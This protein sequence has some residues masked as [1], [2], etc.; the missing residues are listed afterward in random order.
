[1]TDASPRLGAGR[2]DVPV[3]RKPVPPESAWQEAGLF[4]AIAEATEDLVTVVDREARFL[5]VN[6]AGLRFLGPTPE[7]LVG[8]SALDFVHPD[9]Q[10]A[11][12]EAV[13]RW[14]EGD[15]QQ[16]RSIENRQMHRDGSVRHV[17][18]TVTR[19][20]GADGGLVLVSYAKDITPIRRAERLLEERELRLRALLSGM[21][22]AVVAIDPSG[23]VRF[24]SDSVREIFGWEPS[25]LV[26]RNVSVLLPEPHRSLHDDYLARY[27]ETGETWILNTT[28]E[29]EARHR[30]G[31]KFWIELSVSRIDVPG[32]EP[33]FCGAFRDITERKNAHRIVR[34][35]EQRF[36]AIFDQEFQMVGL[37]EPSGRVLEINRAAIQLVGAT[38]E[39]VIGRV[40]WETPWWS[41]SPEL[42]ELCRKWVRRA[43]RGEFVRDEI[44]VRAANGESHVM[45]FSLK[46]VRGEE[47]RVELLIPEA[48]D[49]TELKRA[50]D[51]ETSMLRALA[52]LGE[53]ASL[54]AHEIKNPITSI[55]LALRAVASKLG[56]DE[57]SAIDD[58]LDRLRRLEATLRRTLSFAKPL[59][60]DAHDV[61]VLPLLLGP[62]DQLRPEAESRDVEL[63]LEVDRG[64]GVVRV[65][66]GL[67]GDLIGNLVRNAIDAVADGGHVS[68][69]AQAVDS[70]GV[71]IRVE[72]DGPGIPE[73]VRESL[74]QPFVTTKDRGTGLGLPLARKVAEEHGG[75]LTAF[76]SDRLGGACFQ[77]E[78]PTG[79]A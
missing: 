4:R 78:L 26:G 39:D 68:I 76:R 3:P 23:I 32:L 40:F 6:S 48:R 9:D 37:L 15:P 59:D 46:P 64:C 57:A 69:T 1:M 60:I 5:F 71:R 62:V 19:H 38:R 73:S 53:S 36:R 77:F 74:F 45:D 75:S 7:E 65:D 44:E 63:A 31:H 18:W 22:D 41:S 34:E 35:S 66:E 54:L 2:D 52:A 43:A 47:G 55:H 51:R 70:G 25:E 29:F 13:R 56:E 67:V 33:L 79:A 16:S 28:R 11:T 24:T 30:N 42:P 61:D 21:L 72:D 14:V 8:R 17:L 50:Q 20:T 10:E 27:R 12:R 58:L 49:I